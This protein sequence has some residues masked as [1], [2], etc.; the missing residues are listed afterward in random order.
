ME[1]VKLQNMFHL[2]YYVKL[3]VK[4]GLI[5][6]TQKIFSRYLYSIDITFEG[7]HH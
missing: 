4:H 3:K 5:E 2:N 1:K 6:S 7:F